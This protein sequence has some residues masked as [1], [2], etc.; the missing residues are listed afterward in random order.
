MLKKHLALSEQII[1]G[2]GLSDRE[3]NEGMAGL[4]SSKGTVQK[5]YADLTTTQTTSV[6]VIEDILDFAQKGLGRTTVQNGQP[7]FEIQPELDEYRRLI[8]VLT[9]AAASET[10]VTE[11]VRAQAQISKQAL[12]DQLK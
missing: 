10:A 12:V 8:Q 6:R 1:R 5:N 7:I 2:S 4:N 9:N 3:V 11:K